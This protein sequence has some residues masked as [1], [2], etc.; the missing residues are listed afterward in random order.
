[1]EGEREGGVIHIMTHDPRYEAQG[2]GRCETAPRA[3]RSLAVPLHVM[4]CVCVSYFATRW[5]PGFVAR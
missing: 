5:L 3:P 4:P 1:M 2:T